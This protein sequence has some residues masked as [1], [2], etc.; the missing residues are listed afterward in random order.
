MLLGLKHVC[1]AADF[2]GSGCYYAHQKSKQRLPEDL[3][4]GLG[5]G[6]EPHALTKSSSLELPPPPL[7]PLLNLTLSSYPAL[8]YC[9][10]G[11]THC[12]SLRNISAWAAFPVLSQQGRQL[13]GPWS[14]SSFTSPLLLL[15]FTGQGVLYRTPNTATPGQSVCAGRYFCSLAIHGHFV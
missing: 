1:P 15:L 10:M 2:P 5:W 9:P 11:L 13:P 14:R 6:C 3:W 12:S 7:V 4:L 8:S